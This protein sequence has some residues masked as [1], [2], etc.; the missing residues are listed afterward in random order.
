MKHVTKT[1]V[2]IATSLLACTLC[3]A[4]PQ[5]WTDRGIIDTNAVVND[6]A[7]VNQGQVKHVATQAY[8]EIDQKLTNDCSAIS[9]LVAGFSS[10][11][12]YLSVNLGQLKAV[13]AP[14]YDLLWANDYTNAWPE[15]MTVGPYP[16][17][18]SSNGAQ[19]FAIAN[20]GQL[21]YLFSFYFG[22]LLDSDGDG[23]PD[24]W[25]LL[26]FGSATGALAADDP[27]G[28]G[29]TNLEE[30][31]FGSNPLK[32]DSDEDGLPDKFERDHGLNPN[33]PLDALLDSDGDGLSNLDEYLN[34]T[35]PN[36]RDSDGDGIS[37]RDEL[38]SGG[39]PNAVPTNAVLGTVW[40]DGGSSPAGAFKIQISFNANDLSIVGVGNA[41]EMAPSEVCLGQH[42]EYSSGSVY[43]T[44]VQ[45]LSTNSPTGS[46][47]L[48]NVLFQK[49]S[50]SSEYTNVQVNAGSMLKNAA[51]GSNATH[52]VWITLT[53]LSETL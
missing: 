15:G 34:G 22:T 41:G 44:Y 10:T 38:V 4:M 47:A 36:N 49:A 43:I 5:W 37:D 46:N 28:D 2:A 6:Y 20:I 27:D 18:G 24:W 16:W 31:Q 48:V 13:A 45:S 35:N 19:D 42:P 51:D 26:Y 33:N 11:N 8:L 14:F 40:M 53:D 1:G 52:S 39:N 23:M 3:A 50:P 12:N 25:E 21:K 29:L 32:A 17:S 7:P 9:N 30:Y